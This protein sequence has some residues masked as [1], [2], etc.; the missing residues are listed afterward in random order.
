MYS[1]RSHRGM[2]VGRRKTHGQK[3]GGAVGRSGGMNGVEGGLDGESQVTEAQ[4]HR[5]KPIGPH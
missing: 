4:L 1:E 5:V 3:N 2:G